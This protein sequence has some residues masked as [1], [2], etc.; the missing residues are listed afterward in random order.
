[1]AVLKTTKKTKKDESAKANAVTTM[2]NR[3]KTKKNAVSVVPAAVVEIPETTEAATDYYQNYM[4]TITASSERAQAAAEEAQR[5]K[6]QAAVEANEAYIPRV[7]A[8]T[9]QQLREAYIANMKAKAQA[10]AALS[11]MGYTGGA[12]ESSL[13]GL[14][15]SYQQSRTELE[16]AQTESLADIY[17]NTANIQATG[18]ASLSDLAATYY[19]NLLSAQQ[20]ALAQAQE[21]TNYQT[22]Y[23]ASQLEQEKADYAATIGAY[24]QD[25]A[26]EKAKVLSDGD[27]T[28]DWKA[29]ILEAARQEKLKELAAAAA[30]TAATTNA[31]SKTGTTT[32]TSPTTKTTSPVATVTGISQDTY[33]MIERWRRANTSNNFSAIIKRKIAD[34]TITQQQY[35]DYVNDNISQ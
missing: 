29:T 21:Q 15:T 31:A 8:N 19:Q 11:A 20:N 2:A 14:D 3:A 32:Y 34:G 24:Y 12:A 33:D 28:N 23:E 9:E 30:Q 18:E 4:D 17:A 1:M 13:L 5:L 26:A 25:Y 6:T 27:T 35:V 22:Q 10:P 16:K 7:Q